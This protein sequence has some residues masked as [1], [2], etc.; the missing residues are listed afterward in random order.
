VV[1]PLPEFWPETSEQEEQFRVE[2]RA[3]SQQSPLT[4]S[5]NTFLFH[6]SFPVDARHNAKIFREQLQQ[7]ADQLLNQQKAA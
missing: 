3:V 2:L 4:S 6:R 5:I 7:W 1:E